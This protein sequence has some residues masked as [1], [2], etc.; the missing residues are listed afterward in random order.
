SLEA[1]AGTFI[2]GMAGGQHSK[3]LSIKSLPLIINGASHTHTYIHTHRQTHTHLYIHTHRHTP[4]YTHRD[5]HLCTHTQTDTHTHTHTHT[6]TDRDTV[7]VSD[8]YR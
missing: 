2:V 1:S 8:D 3:S 4:I 7:Q 6:H 5:T